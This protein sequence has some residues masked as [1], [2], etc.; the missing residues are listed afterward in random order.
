MYY[1]ESGQEKNRRM[2]NALLLACAA[3]VVLVAAISF[4]FNTGATYGPQIEVTLATRPASQAPDEARHIAQSSQEGSVEEAQAQPESSIPLPLE[5]PAASTPPQEAKTGQAR[6]ADLLST[7]AAAPRAVNDERA[8]Q[9]QRPDEQARALPDQPRVRRLA[10]VATRESA[11]AAYLHSFL[12][13]LEAVGNKYY[14]EAS[15]RYGL[16]G[17]LRLLVAVR[18]D[19]G[20]EE[21]RVLESSGYAVLDEAAIKTVRMA[22]P[23]AP[24]PEELSATTDR[25][26]IV[27][28]WHFEQNELSSNKA[29]AN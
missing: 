26:E 1:L 27:R 10:P 13:R 6:D 24:F 7:A 3:H 16:Y 11:D 12:K 15:V 9:Q 19:G 14:P 20:L 18:S 23:F 22:A 17:S 25:L 29:P 4:D 2:R 8:E 28:T 21:I 5:N